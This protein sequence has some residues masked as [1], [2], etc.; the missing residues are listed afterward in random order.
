MVS[1]PV[2]FREILQLFWENF[3]FFLTHVI[4]SISIWCNLSFIHALT[5]SQKT[6]VETVSETFPFGIFMLICDFVHYFWLHIE[7]H[8]VKISI[9][10][11]TNYF[12]YS[13]VMF[14]AYS[15]SVSF[16]IF[17]VLFFF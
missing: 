12:R 4:I 5:R 17:H 15:I 7:N 1:C 2:T 11:A 13:D 9:Y 10:L 6:E 3:S 14:R 16:R 8:F